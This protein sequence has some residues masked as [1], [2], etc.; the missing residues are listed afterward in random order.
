MSRLQSLKQYINQ[1]LT[2]AVED[3]FEHFERTITEY[4]E[5]MDLRHRK[6]CELDSRTEV[7]LQ[8]EAGQITLSEFM[9]GAQKDE[10]LMNLLKLD[11]DAKG[12]VIQ[13][14]GKTS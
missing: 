5:E 13:N 9:E 8:T 12:W 10:W 3:I 2:A 7:H 1:R 4:E 11:V 6:L 14:C